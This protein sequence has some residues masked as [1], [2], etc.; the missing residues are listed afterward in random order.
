MVVVAIL[1]C[2]MVVRKS[3]LAAGGFAAGIHLPCSGTEDSVMLSSGDL[4]NA[5]R[6][7]LFRA[8]SVD[9]LWSLDFSISRGISEAGSGLGCV[10]ETPRP[11][12]ALFVDR[13]GGV[14]SSADVD[15]FPQP[16]ANDNLLGGHTM[17]FSPLDDL[18]PKLTLFSRTPGID[19]TVGGEH[20][21]MVVT[22][23]HRDKLLWVARLGL[24]IEDGDRVKLV[25]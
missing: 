14:V 7:K 4:N 8:E 22:S 2:R 23:R 6:A 13:K 9:E 21:E 12:I 19:V 18:A 3:E 5:I 10:V 16:R 15:S 24:D 17:G 11:D 1:E 20:N 25:F